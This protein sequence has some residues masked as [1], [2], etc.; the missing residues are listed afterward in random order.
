MLKENKDIYLVAFVDPGD[1]EVSALRTFFF[2]TEA[3]SSF[4]SSLRVFCVFQS[5]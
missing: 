2:L 3:L 5:N 4:M 1:S